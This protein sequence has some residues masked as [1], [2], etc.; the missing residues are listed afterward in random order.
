MRI[1][2]LII[3]TTMGFKSRVERD[4]NK[5]FLNNKNFG[6]KVD[7]GGKVMNVT[8]DEDA[9][10]ERNLAL[11]KDGKLH[12]DNVLFYCN[13]NE[14]E[15]RVPRVEELLDFGKSQYVVTSV[16]D[17]MG[18]LTITLRSYRGR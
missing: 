18:M 1:T 17:D 5:V 14:F 13:K 10:K 8:I 7:V 16:K 3:L 12:T 4:I 9:L 6:S 2:S 15:R 11:I